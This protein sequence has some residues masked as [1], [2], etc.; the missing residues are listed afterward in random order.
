MSSD[1]S[2]LDTRKKPAPTDWHPADIQA[3]LKKAGW[4]FARLSRANDYAVGCANNATRTPWPK[5]ERLI[6]EAI[7]LAPQQIWPSRYNDNGT[8]KSGRG[9]RGG[10]PKRKASRPASN[11]STA[12]RRRNVET[13]GAV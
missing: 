8:P 1:M 3:A 11:H 13:R 6:A 9:E 12:R 4:S 10:S 5:M 2:H 7:G